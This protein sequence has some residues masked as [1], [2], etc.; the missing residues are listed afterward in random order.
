MR[1]DLNRLLIALLIGAT[2]ASCTVSEEEG[3]L[4]DNT[5]S[6][7]DTVPDT[8]K[9][10]QW[11]STK[12]EEAH[13]II[14]DSGYLYVA[15]ET[16]GDIEGSGNAG[17]SDIF[18]TKMTSTGQREWTRSFGTAEYDAGG[19]VAIDAQGMVYLLGD[20]QGVLEGATELGQED[21][22]L[23][24]WD[25]SGN[26]LW[27]RQWGTER[28]DNARG[29]LVDKNDIV[30]VLGE[31]DGSF[32]GIWNT[33]SCTDWSEITFCDDIFLSKFSTDGVLIETIQWGSADNRN[34]S[35]VGLATDQDGNLYVSGYT[36]GV[37][38]GNPDAGDDSNVF[39]SKWRA[40][41]HYAG[42]Q[43]WSM[44]E[45]AYGGAIQVDD[46]GNIFLLGDITRA[47]VSSS[48]GGKRD[49]FLSKLH[50]D[51][52]TAWM[53]IWGS[54]ENED[55]RALIV[56]TA[57]NIYVVGSTQG[58]MDGFTQAGTYCDDPCTDIFVTMWRNNGD[59]VRTW[60]WG[61]KTLDTPYAIGLSGIGL[62]VAGTTWGSME[63]NARVDRWDIFVSM[64][65]AIELKEAT[66]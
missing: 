33:E 34:D 5:A 18:L 19:F 52:T 3:F 25:E 57:G 50:P 27:E 46:E 32:D 21:M 55:N 11:G 23:S 47:E 36:F 49:V 51:G 17:R 56:D 53:R 9:H 31:T 28:E 22:L 15:G 61:T 30:V 4:D 37:F 64:I 6:D 13:S 43:Q 60:Q 38:S 62:F 40:D 48:E 65:P 41:G 16:W 12:D 59:K 1:P 39:F 58:D 7:A 20:T 10:L 26:K 42:T 35:P 66:P 44:G 8:K 29:I 2:L 24:K 45:Q 14:A 63:A 54:S